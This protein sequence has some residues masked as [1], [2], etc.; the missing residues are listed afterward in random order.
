MNK[1]RYLR[2]P[3]EKIVMGEWTETTSGIPMLKVKKPN[4]NVYEDI[5]VSKLIRMLSRR[6]DE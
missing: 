3:K 5:P 2:T 4:A 1:D 6:L